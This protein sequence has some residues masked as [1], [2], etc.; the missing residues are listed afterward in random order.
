MRAAA[1]GISLLHFSWG[2]PRRVLPVILA[3]RSPDFPHRQAFRPAGAAV[4]LTCER[5]CTPFQ[6]GLSNQSGLPIEIFR[7]IVYNTLVKLGKGE[8]CY[9]FHHTG[10]SLRPEGQEGGGD[11][12]RRIHTPLIKMLLR[13]G[14]SVTACD[15]NAREDFG[16]QAEALESLGATLC[17]GPDYL[18]HLDHDV[19]FRTPGLR[20]DVPQLLAAKERGS[21]ITSEMEVFF[22]VCP[23]KTIAVTGATGRPPPPPSS[24]SCSRRRGRACTWGATSASPCCPTWT[25]WS[26]RISPCWSCPPSADDHG[27]QP[28]IAVVTNWPPITWMCTPP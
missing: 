2:R 22:T 7:R 13:A 10:V 4:Q 16:G 17:L 28:D 21:V 24:P 19:I 3:L 20:P 8:R 9:A 14:I 5:Y 6:G 1:G 15:K 27:A 18:D 12:H 11:R 25:G 26:R 23:C